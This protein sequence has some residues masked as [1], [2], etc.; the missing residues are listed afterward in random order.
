MDFARMSD[1]IRVFHPTHHD[2]HDDHGAPFPVSAALRLSMFDPFDHGGLGTVRGSST[3]ADVH[4][5][6]LSSHM[7]KAGPADNHGKGS[8]DPSVSVQADQHAPA[9]SVA[10][11]QNGSDAAVTKLSSIDPVAGSAHLGG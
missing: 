9:K 11:P 5:A 4:A 8:K 10:F 7:R 3:G 2:G 6:S 1:G